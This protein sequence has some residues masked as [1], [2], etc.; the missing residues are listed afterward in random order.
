M[1]LLVTGAAGYVGHRFVERA[2]AEGAHVRALLHRDAPGLPSSTQRVTCDLASPR[3]D[4]RA[5]LC[6]VDAVV[7]CAASVRSGDAESCRRVNVEGT[8]RLLCAAERAGVARFVHLGSV[9]VYGWQRPG[10]VLTPQSPLELR[11]ELREPYAWSK[12]QAER[13]VALHRAMGRID[14][15][16]LRL[17]IVYGRGR[18]FVARIF[19]YLGRRALLVWGTPR[20]ILPLVHVDDVVEAMWRTTLHDGSMVPA[21]DVVGP[22]SPRQDAYLALRSE[23]ST[24]AAQVAY[25]PAKAAQGCARLLARHPELRPSRARS[26]LYTLAW[27][28]QETRFDPAPCTA[29]LGWAPR[30]DAARGLSGIGTTPIEEAT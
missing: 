1:I 4:L 30:I 9:A 5:A 16:S 10:R 19:R 6:G 7:H 2:V 27:S 21:I 20:M 18:D 11:P 15:V 22:S 25:L 17:G 29:A 26:L 23:R 12:I 3:V 24:P 13:I 8:R 28:V 14:A